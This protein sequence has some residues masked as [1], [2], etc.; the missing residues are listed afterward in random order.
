[1]KK[2]LLLILLSLSI[3]G[4]QTGCSDSAKTE[5]SDAALPAEEQ[6]EEKDEEP[7]TEEVQPQ[8]TE[9]TEETD[10]QEEMS[11]NFYEFTLENPQTDET[12]TAVV[13]YTFE[14]EYQDEDGNTYGSLSFEIPQLTMRS[15]SAQTIN[16]DI[17]TQF[18]ESLLSSDS[19]AE[20]FYIP[21]EEWANPDT[22][23]YSN[24]MGYTVTYIGDE[25]ICLLLD[26]YVYTGGAHGSPYRLPLIYSLESG[27]TV[28][29]EDLFEITED[30]FAALYVQA[31]EEVIAEE[32]DGYWED[33]M[34]TVN[35]Y[36]NL[37]NEYFYLTE[38]GATFYF[39]PYALAPYARGYV[40]IEIPY[41]QLQ[42]K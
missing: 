10:A 26:G 6:I 34:D 24:N 23:Q 36:A 15:I 27:E 31:F 18:H 28:Q 29:M 17:L 14:K 21:A 40:E 19:D 5:Q 20:E 39:D 11:G 42:L 13:Y 9:D 2:K 12:T 33:A 32:P 16:Q 1:M 3:L 4:V 38:T 41:E 7:E 25:W 8:E 35:E 37:Q 22:L 30:E